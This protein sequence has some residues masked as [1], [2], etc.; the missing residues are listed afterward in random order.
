MPAVPD[1]IIFCP[2]DTQRHFRNAYFS[3][4]EPGGQE[5]CGP[6]KSVVLSFS[7]PNGAEPVR[8]KSTSLTPTA[9]QGQGFP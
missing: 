2:Q 7:H 8:R 3:Y 9:P 5:V 1:K 4:T 6:G